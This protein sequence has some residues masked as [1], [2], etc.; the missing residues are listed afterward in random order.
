MSA[1]WSSMHQVK[2][3]DMIQHDSTCFILAPAVVNRFS[4]ESILLFGCGSSNLLLS[5]RQ[6]SVRYRHL[7]TVRQDM[8][9]EYTLFRLHGLTLKYFADLCR[10]HRCADL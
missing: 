9:R 6:H 10:L 3:T 1:P 5:F 4:N 7:K 2:R 8:Q